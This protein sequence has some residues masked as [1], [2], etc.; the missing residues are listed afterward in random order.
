MSYGAND[1]FS[2]GEVTVGKSPFHRSTSGHIGFGRSPSSRGSFRHTPFLVDPD[3]RSTLYLIAIAAFNVP[4]GCMC[5]TMGLIVLNKEADHLFP[6]AP[7]M[8]LGMFMA[9]VGFTQLV[10][11]L[12]G[13][14][15]DRC[16]AS[17]GRRRPFIGWGSL[18]VVVGIGIM[19][20][21]S[22]HSYPWMYSGAL[23]FSM[24]NVNIVFS[25]CTGLVPDLVP[26]HQRGEASGIVSVLMLLG[27]VTG[28]MFVDGTAD[29]DYRWCY[30]F[31][32]VEM[33]IFVSIV[34]IFAKE[35]PRLPLDPDDKIDA[36]M[37]LDSYTVTMGPEGS[38]GQYDF[39]WV[40]IGR[41]MF[42]VAVSA[43]AFM[44][45]Y[46]R[47]MVG[48]KSDAAQRQEVSRIVIVGQG[49][50]AIVALPCG[51]LSDKIGRK[52]LVYM[53]C[54]V[55]CLVYIGFLEATRFDNAILVIYFVAALYGLGNGCYLSVDLALA[56]DCL[57]F[58][59]DAAKDLGVWGVAAFVGS[60]VG[61]MLWATSFTVVGQHPDGGFKPLAY[62]L[63]LMGGCC[64][65]IL[66]GAL[67]GFI[68]VPK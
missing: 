46:F 12:A 34:L 25:G 68:K 51:M 66:A 19:S 36:T 23:F 45:W 4:Y 48:L 37:I 16:T 64:F 6:E 54:F 24:L 39:L 14:A 20:W 53:A 62:E 2:R 7:A 56:I 8:A 33:V 44:Q 43:Q 60:A 52:P 11:P 22:I 41:T 55:M 31:Y 15:S 47:D 49:V 38:K 13:L 42:Y 57:P 27:S 10:C 5:A 26:E 1:S 63:M 59:E 50:A 9:L 29:L 58:P 65:A 40:F 67:I 18:G 21:A 30:L 17:Y 28:F 32:A 3:T 61:P 35:I